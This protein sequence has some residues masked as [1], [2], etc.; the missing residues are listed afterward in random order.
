MARSVQTQVDSADFFVQH[1]D[2]PSSLIATV[3]ATNG[4]A[5]SPVS[6]DQANRVHKGLLCFVAISSVTV[7]T[8]TLAVNVNAK[9]P[10]SGAYVQVG[11]VSLDGITTTTNA[12]FEF[13]P[14]LTGA[15]RDSMVAP[16]LY[17]VQA[18]LTVTTT[19]SMTGTVAYR[20]SGSR[21][22]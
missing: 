13:Y 15:S 21:L 9:D 16:A 2:L 10:I 6:A 12:A 3:T 7:N 14:G 18:S 11:R 4:S 1:Q 22:L 8:A 20:V 19:A 17:Q 5:T